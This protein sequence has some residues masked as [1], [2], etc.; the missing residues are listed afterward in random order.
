MTSIERLVLSGMLKE[1]SAQML[2]R[3]AGR[4]ELTDRILQHLNRTT[5]EGLD[6]V[7]HA[8][9][10][11]ALNK[12][13]RGTLAMLSTLGQVDRPF[14]YRGPLNPLKAMRQD[15]ALRADETRL[16]NSRF[17]DAYRAKLESERRFGK[18]LLLPG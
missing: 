3:V 15:L 6:G 11:A 13:P 16:R 4:P 18:T 8:D 17:K 1:A 10:F 5:W 9:T 12:D 14:Y 2:R 7:S